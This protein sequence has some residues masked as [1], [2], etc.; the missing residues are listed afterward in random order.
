MFF[1]K[2]QN[3]KNYMISIEIDHCAY[4]QKFGVLKDVRVSASAH[5]RAVKRMHAH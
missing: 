5:M 3:S 4:I 1:N 2:K